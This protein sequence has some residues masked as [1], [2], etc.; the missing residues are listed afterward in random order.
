ME[1]YI[2][3]IIKWVCEAIKW[4]IS[5]CN[6][7]AGFISA[8]LAITAIV[9]TIKVT[10]TPYEEKLHF[11]EY[12]F[13]DNEGIYTITI[14]LT[15]IGNVPIMFDELSVYNGNKKVGECYDV[16]NNILK[17]GEMKEYEF[18]L[19]EINANEENKHKKMKIIAKSKNKKFKFKTDWAVG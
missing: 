16:Y 8:I 19:S 7:N 6:D 3:C 17:P 14:I 18:Y 11:N 15:N 1:N 4:V 13:Y 5:Q 9:A 10:K 2:F 12:L